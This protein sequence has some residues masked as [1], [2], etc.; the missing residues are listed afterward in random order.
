MAKRKGVR[1]TVIN[2]DRCGRDCDW[3]SYTPLI[4]VDGRTVGSI[5]ELV[6]ILK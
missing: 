2:V 1:V 3:V 4:K 5:R 6:K